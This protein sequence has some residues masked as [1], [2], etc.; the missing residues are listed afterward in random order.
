MEKVYY[1]AIDY[2]KV[3]CAILVVC[4]H[5]G[6]LLSVN[7]EMNFFLVQVL[8]RMAVPYIF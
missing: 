7:E 1:K 4:I 5:T 6:P 2:V 8:A 3:I